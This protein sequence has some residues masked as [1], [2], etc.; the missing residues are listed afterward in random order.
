MHL[1]PHLRTSFPLIAASLAIAC[2]ACTAMPDEPLASGTNNDILVA[3]STNAPP[4]PPSQPTQIVKI[5]VAPAVETAAQ[6]PAGDPLMTPWRHYVDGQLIVMYQDGH[7]SAA[8]RAANQQIGAKVIQAFPVM[9]G[10]LVALPAGMSVPEAVARYQA[11]PGVINVS[12][13]AVA[14]EPDTVAMH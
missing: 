2:T 4:A 11:L 9:R 14:T 7:R 13:N 1:H 10:A 8:A 3:Q 6:T 12:P 5:E